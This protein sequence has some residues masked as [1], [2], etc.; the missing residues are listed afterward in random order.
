MYAYVVNIPS[1]ETADDVRDLKDWIA[2]HQSSFDPPRIG[3][4]GAYN[5]VLQLFEENGVVLYR[6]GYDFKFWFNEPELAKE[7]AQRYGTEVRI[8]L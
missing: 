4:N 3:V 8:N 1:P 2:A 5:R 7:F 6:R